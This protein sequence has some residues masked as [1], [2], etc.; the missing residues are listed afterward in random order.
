MNDRK[1]RIT[2]GWQVLVALLVVAVGTAGQGRESKQQHEH[3]AHEDLHQ[4]GRIMAQLGA[5]VTQAGWV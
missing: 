5:G 1:R 2:L 4:G 3:V